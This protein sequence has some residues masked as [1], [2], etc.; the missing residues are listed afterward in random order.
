ML[1]RIPGFFAAVQEVSHVGIFLRL[2]DTQLRAACVGHDLAKN[3]S[4]LLRRED[5]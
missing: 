2:C 4:E 3:V 5:R 1:P